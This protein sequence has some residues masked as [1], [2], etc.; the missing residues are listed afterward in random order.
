MGISRNGQ[1]ILTYVL[2]VGGF[3]KTIVLEDE[4]KF[5]KI[6]TTGEIP[7]M[8]DRDPDMCDPYDYLLPVFVAL[9]KVERN[10]DFRNKSPR[11]E[12]S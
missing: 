11:G 1:Y 12:S 7:V 2:D 5:D 9:S 4:S 8:T 3:Y 6:L 10:Y